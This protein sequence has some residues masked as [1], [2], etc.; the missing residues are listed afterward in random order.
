MLW[1]TPFERAARRRSRRTGIPSGCTTSGSS[2]STRSHTTRHAPDALEGLHCYGRG[3]EEN[4]RD[5]N[6]GCDV[7]AYVSTVTDQ[8]TVPW[9][10]GTDRHGPAR[11]AR[12]GGDPEARPGAPRGH[13]VSIGAAS[14]LG[15]VDDGSS[16][17][18]RLGG[19]EKEFHPASCREGLTAVLRDV[20]LRNSQDLGHPMVVT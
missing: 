20:N 11:M 9:P 10:A 12:C 5:R 13:E 8:W 3:P 16:S 15:A 1:L 2:R 18:L 17:F 4:H 7:G 6:D 19:I 14:G